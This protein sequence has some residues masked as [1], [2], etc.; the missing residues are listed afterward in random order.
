VQGVLLKQAPRRGRL[1]AAPIAAVRQA[2]AM[3]KVAP[4]TQPDVEPVTTDNY[5]RAA[6]AL[7]RDL[8]VVRVWCGD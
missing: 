6:D 7:R 4:V 1:Y 5:G 3:A 2:M 8:R